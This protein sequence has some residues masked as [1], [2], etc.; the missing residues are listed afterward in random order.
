MKNE[1]EQNL[2]DT[3]GNTE[4]SNRKISQ[5]IFDVHK[6]FKL[7]VYHFQNYQVREFEDAMLNASYKY[8]DQKMFLEHHEMNYIK[9]DY[10]FIHHTLST[11]IYLIFSV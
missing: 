9:R 6:H 7:A 3:Y 8:P 2:N 1:G 11:M 10:I 4:S 5:D